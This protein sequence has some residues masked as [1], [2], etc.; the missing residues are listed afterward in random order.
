MRRKCLRTVTKCLAE[1]ECESFQTKFADHGHEAARASGRIALL[2]SSLVQHK[3][4]ASWHRCEPEAPIASLP[5]Q[6]LLIVRSA[7]GEPTLAAQETN[8]KNAVFRS[9][10]IDP[11]AAR[12]RGLTFFFSC[13]RDQQAVE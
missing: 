6:G 9:R 2:I 1:N 11:V 10:F 7:L 12:L 4:A 8:S 3:S 13:W 5:R